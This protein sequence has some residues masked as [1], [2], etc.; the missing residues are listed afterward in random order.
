MR[1][2]MEDGEHPERGCKYLCKAE[3]ALSKGGVLHWC[4]PVRGASTS[5]M[6]QQGHLAHGGP[7][8]GKAI[9]RAHPYSHICHKVLSHSSFTASPGC[10]ALNV[11]PH[12]EPHAALSLSAEQNKSRNPSYLCYINIKNTWCMALGS[13]LQFLLEQGG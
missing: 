11:R 3:K 4:P 10:P 5:S 8:L 12:S 13:L 1:S 6:L 2:P 7:P 9:L